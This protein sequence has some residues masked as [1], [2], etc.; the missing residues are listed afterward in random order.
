MSAPITTRGIVLRR[1]PY[2]ETSVILTVF[3][4]KW[5]LRKYMV[6]GVRSSRAKS[7]GS[8]FQPTSLLEMVV[9]HREDRDLN[10][11]GEVRAS[12]VYRSVPFE[13]IRGAVG[14]FMAE[15]LQKTV[16]ESDAAPDLFVFVHESFVLLD[17]W[18]GSIA[19]LP[20]WYLVKLSS[21]LGIRPGGSWTQETPVFDLREGIFVETGHD[22]A[23][24]L[25]AEESEA[26]A[27]IEARPVAEVLETPLG[28]ALRRGLLDGLL[29]YYRL[30]L[31]HLPEIH[32]HQILQEVLRS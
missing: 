6:N 14:L 12:H 24:A 26:L 22:G 29:R 4:E 19:N 21:F 13:V 16:R 2:S 32:A 1:I 30:Q 31:D 25:G 8:L 17:Q 20:V 18:E 5:G 3:T 15:I 9:Y 27:L 28:A 10:R 7:K 23:L 11:L